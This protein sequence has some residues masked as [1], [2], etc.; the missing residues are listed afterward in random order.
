[1]KS[2]EEFRAPLRIT[3]KKQAELNIHHKVPL[4]DHIEL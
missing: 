3:E 2:K 1:M 4:D